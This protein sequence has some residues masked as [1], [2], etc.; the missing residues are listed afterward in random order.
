MILPDFKNPIVQQKYRYT[1]L[2]G[3]LIFNSLLLQ[4]LLYVENYL[5]MYLVTMPTVVLLIFRIIELKTVGEKVGFVKYVL[6]SFE[7][8][9]SVK[10]Y[11]KLENSVVIRYICPSQKF[12]AKFKQAKKYIEKKSK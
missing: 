4:Y 3:G 8:M 11:E 10:S 6:D 12:L 7:W 1:F 2:C 9:H 5:P